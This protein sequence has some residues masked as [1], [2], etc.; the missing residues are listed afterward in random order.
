MDKLVRFLSKLLTILL[1]A[2][3]PVFAYEVALKDGRVIKFQK[4]R[5]TETALLYIV[6]QGKE[7]SIPLSSVDPDRTRELNIKENPPLNL[8]GVIAASASGNADSLPSLGEI[9]RK[10]RKDEP[11]AAKHA[12]TTDDLASGSSEESNS[13]P[14][15]GSDPETW[16]RRLDDVRKKMEPFK[17][18]DSAELARLALGNLDVDFP[19]RKEWEDR[20]FEQ[21]RIVLNLAQD[22]ERAFQEY[23][24]LRDA[25]TRV[26]GLTK[27]EEDRYEEARKR[28]EQAIDRPRTQGHQL[29]S[30]IN[31]GKKR[32]IAWKKK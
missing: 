28:L 4:Y 8:P 29:D 14:V 21:K 11:R 1:F 17:N 12:Y 27:G 16:R 20:L 25:M 10:L 9:A 24:E 26:T 3:L 18:M 15:K 32:A 2:A 23:Q 5:A 6:D 7:I 31:D 19:G 13:G 30:V 22:A